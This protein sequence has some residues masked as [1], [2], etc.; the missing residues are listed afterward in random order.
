MVI[1]CNTGYLHDFVGDHEW[2]AMIPQMKAAHETLHGRSGLGNDFLGWMDLPVAY[3]KEEFARIQK[4]AEKIKNDSEVLIVI[5]IGGSYLGARA[6][7]EQ[8]RS[9]LYNNKKKD[10][11]RYLLCG[12]FHYP[13]YLNEVLSICEGRDLSVNV[14]SNPVPPLSRRWLFVFSGNCWS[15]NTERKEPSTAFM[16]Q[17]IRRRGH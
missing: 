7:I 2:E 16:R 9:P 6:V 4:A 17:R 1:K 8:L 3:D 13:T 5:G 11:A 12:K 15:K 10:T 14:I